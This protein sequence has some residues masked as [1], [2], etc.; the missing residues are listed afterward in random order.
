MIEIDGRGL[1]RSGEARIYTDEGAGSPPREEEMSRGWRTPSTNRKELERSEAQTEDMSV[2]VRFLPTS[3]V[4]THL[5][6]PFF[7]FCGL[8]IRMREE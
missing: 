8:K 1:A 5:T 7:L 4:I 3:R 2:P 6:L